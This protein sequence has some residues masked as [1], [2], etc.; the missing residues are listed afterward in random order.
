MPFQ[1]GGL[2]WHCSAPIKENSLVHDLDLPEDRIMTRVADLLDPEVVEEAAESVNAK[3]GRVDALIHLVGGWTG[4]KTIAESAAED[5]KF[6]LDQHA[7]TTIH[8][9]QDIIKPKVL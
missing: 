2:P 7:W 1:I 5:F 6:M 3:F 8:L 9:L 4:G